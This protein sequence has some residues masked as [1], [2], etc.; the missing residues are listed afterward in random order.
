[1]R[2]YRLYLT[3]QMVA[4]T[5]LWMQRIA[6][7]WLVLELTGSVTAVGVAVAL[8][9][10]P[11][12]MFGLFGGV[13][14]DRFPK[15]TILI[16]TQSTLAAVATTLGV[17]ALTG[18]VE[19][20]HVYVL[21]FV[22][23][24]VTVVDN[25]TRQVFVSELVGQAHIRNAVS[26]NSSVFQLGA[27]VGP[28]V[29]GALIHA[30]GQGWSFLINAASCLVVVIMVAVIRPRPVP[31]HERATGGRGELREALRYI[32]RTSE[33]GWSIA[34]AATIGL[35]GLNMPVILAAF[36]DHVFSTG[37]RG[38]SLFNSL[39]AVGA[40]AGAI[41]S[42]RRQSVP[43]LRALTSNLVLLGGGLMLAAFAPSVWVFGAALVAVGFCTLQFLTGANSLVQTT[44]APAL[45]GRVMG[46]YLLVLLGGQALGGP[47][48]GWLIDHY[49]ARASMF[50]C[51]TLVAL[52]SVAAGLVMAR[53]SHLTVE[54]ELRGSSRLPLHIVPAHH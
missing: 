34:L 9:F 35:F 36:A 31:A 2:D 5:G 1:M 53:R 54:L 49:G 46:V 41:L 21:A 38:Y 28:A 29:S 30:V 37:V 7:D 12:L 6:Q 26:L 16:V 47:C 39:S 11:M 45:R 44:A 50:G 14:A 19:A 40:L 10:L 33:V 22:L 20:W 48:V 52:V 42:A 27:L 24:M 15:R 32:G 51:G 18:A 17:L 23:G 43:R 3:S 13:V 8:Q 25:P 4:T